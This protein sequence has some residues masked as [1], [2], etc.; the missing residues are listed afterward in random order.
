[1]GPAY[2]EVLQSDPAKLSVSQLLPLSLAS[3]SWDLDGTFADTS[4]DLAG[5]LNRTRVE[6]GMEPLPVPEVARHVGRG[7]RW[8]VKN[9][10]DPDRGPEA[11]DHVVQRFLSHYLECCS[12]T[13]QAYPGV[14]DY[15]RRL[16]AAGINQSL[17]T[18][19]PRRFTER[20]LEELNWGELFDTVH[21]GDDGLAK[22]DPEMLRVCMEGNGSSPR[23]HLH[24]GDTPT[25]A[26]A[27]EAAGCYFLG[28]SWGMDG[29]EGLQCSGHQ[30][31]FA[32]L[33]SLARHLERYP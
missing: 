3:V 12:E 24:I 6:E 25:D 8:L 16:R 2:C 33:P 14:I 32:D 10:L 13:T 18:N 19:K 21:C 31:L 20:I 11:V 27:A 22:P 23:A 30:P 1:M 17:A 15:C 9:C 28:V 4:T 26:K 7:A 5:A 29:G